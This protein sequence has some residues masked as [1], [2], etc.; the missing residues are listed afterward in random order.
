LT[1][2][3]KNQRSLIAQRTLYLLA[4]VASLALLVFLRLENAS[5]Q[6]A[7]VAVIT[8]LLWYGAYKLS[9][10]ERNNPNHGEVD[11]SAGANPGHVSSVENYY[12][13][14]LESMEKNWLL[15]DSDL[16]QAQATLRN[17]HHALVDAIDNAKSTG[18]LAL[19]SMVA[20]AN[21]G[22]VG[23]GFVTVSRDLVSI[24]E[25]SG[26]D[27]E[28]MNN[29]VAGAE[30]RLRKTRRLFDSPWTECIAAPGRQWVIELAESIACT[31]GAQEELRRI[32][33]RYQR[34]SKSD[35]RW[36]QLGD[37]VRRLLNELINVL[38][39]FELRMMDVISDLRLV[40]LS[41]TLS[42]N[43]LLEFKGG[44]STGQA[45]EGSK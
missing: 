4:W 9:I 28:K 30:Q 7:F 32:A 2:K 1:D 45:R 39:Q 25:Q 16:D 33:E 44:F 10:S 17:V 35:V 19:N 27:L 29:V 3:I 34:S 21:T 26:Q 37:A 23:R 11:F 12:C 43:Q 22:E 24:S 36:L 15:C 31:Q 38:Y 42:E 8:C 13:R 18:M 40:K 41:G 20:A 6:V 5:I 14:L